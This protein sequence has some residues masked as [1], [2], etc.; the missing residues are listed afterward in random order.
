M[1]FLEVFGECLAMLT[2]CF[3][4]GEFFI[5]FQPDTCGTVREGSDAGLVA[6]DSGLNGT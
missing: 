5:F 2:L 6:A 1:A 4:L 3:S